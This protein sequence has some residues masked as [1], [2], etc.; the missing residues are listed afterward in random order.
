MKWFFSL[1]IAFTIYTTATAQNFKGSLFVG[2]N[3]SHMRGDF[4]TGYSKPGFNIGF[5]VAYPFKPNLDL[6]FAL[7]YSQK[8]SRRTYNRYGNPNS[9]SWHLMRVNYFE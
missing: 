6:S 5:R 9:G 4:M 7:S 2:S 3:W 1:I 8:G